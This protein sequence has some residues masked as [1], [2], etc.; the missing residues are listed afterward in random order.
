[1][2]EEL[3]EYFSDPDSVLTTEEAQSKSHHKL[4]M[5][6]LGQ[7]VL[8]EQYKKGLE[9]VSRSAYQ[10]HIDGAK[11]IIT[12]EVFDAEGCYRGKQVLTIN[13]PHRERVEFYNRDNKLVQTEEGLCGLVTKDGTKTE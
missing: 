8:D 10:Y 3:R 9:L 5:N 11:E 1:M 2:I 13:P 6:D 4:L 12:K 7:V